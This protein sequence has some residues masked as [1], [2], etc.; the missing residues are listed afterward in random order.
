MENQELDPSPVRSPDKILPFLFDI[1]AIFGLIMTLSTI[2][3]PARQIPNILFLASVGVLHII[4][5]IRT[6]R[7]EGGLAKQL[8]LCP[9]VHYLTI[10]FTVAV[11]GSCP[12]LYVV[13]YGVFF[14][15]RV[16]ACTVERGIGPVLMREALRRM[17]MSQFFVSIPSYVEIALCFELAWTALVHFT[18][19]AW[20]SLFVYIGWLVLFNFASSEVHARVWAAVSLFLRKVAAKHAETFGPMLEAIIDKVG[21][22]GAT[23]VEFYPRKELKVHLH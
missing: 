18:P 3:Y 11:S 23:V 2:V 19:I 10:L 7:Y 1:F 21:W 15:A 6:V 14:A 13:L 20:V 17:M 5:T 12:C 4:G 8:L 22:F 16:L 9:D